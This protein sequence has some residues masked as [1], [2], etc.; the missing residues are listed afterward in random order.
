MTGKY[1]PE[2]PNA[3]A[4]SASHH[5]PSVAQAALRYPTLIQCRCGR[6]AQS[7][8]DGSIKQHTIRCTF[9]ALYVAGKNVH[10]A[11]E[12]WMELMKAV[13][14]ASTTAI[15]AGLCP[16]MGLEN[17]ETRG[18][19]KLDLDT[20]QA[21]IKE[22][23]TKADC[24]DWIERQKETISIDYDDAEKWVITDIL[25]TVYRG[26]TL[27][28]CVQSAIAMKPENPLQEEESK[29]P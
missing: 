25:D 15:A 7:G 11:V 21:T 22:W 8:Y 20:I 14:I 29:H 3:V 5:P 27:L 6:T 23:R 24:F 28:E 1:P 9:C 4:P 18:I 13:D 19:D 26:E 12:R 16:G 2:L 17:V 10:L